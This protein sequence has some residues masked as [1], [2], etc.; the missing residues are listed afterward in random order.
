MYIT[1]AKKIEED[2]RKLDNK[3][4]VP[5]II[6]YHQVDQVPQ[7]L[8]E[9]AT[10]L[11]SNNL[12]EIDEKI[13]FINKAL[14]NPNLKNKKMIKALETQ[15][16]DLHSNK[17]LRTGYHKT[18]KEAGFKIPEEYKDMSVVTQNN[19]KYLFDSK[20][21]LLGNITGVSKE[22][23]Y[24]GSAGL[25]PY[26]HGTHDAGKQ[27]QMAKTL[28]RSVHH[29]LYNAHGTPLQTRGNFAYTELPE[30]GV[31]VRRKRAS[32]MWNSGVAKGWFEDTG[33]GTYKVI[34][35]AGGIVTDLTH[36]E[37]QDYIKQGYIVEDVD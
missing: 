1:L 29:G 35:R 34:K 32:D 23:P 7:H 28:Y 27:S 3:R 4:I 18:M 2:L 10:L 19:I 37:I 22:S 11:S 14:K 36:A 9:D 30:N 8:I 17:W 6:P 20:G 33:S 16:E 24:I 13:D 12:K 26:L 25:M 15:L 5:D 21:N 31:P